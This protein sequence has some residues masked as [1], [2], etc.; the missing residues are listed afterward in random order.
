[1]V[2]A[3]AEDAAGKF[4]AG[5]SDGLLVRVTGD[6]LVEETSRTT[7]LSIRGLYATPNGDLWLGFA[8]G[9]VGRLRDGQLQRFTTEQG[10]PNDYVSQI[11]PDDRDSLWF[12]GNQGIFQVR[13]RDFDDVSRGIVTRLTPMIYGRGE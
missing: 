1:F 10:L 6:E 7:G 2:R 3:M 8:G 11:L 5:A 9:G 12:A 13:E 4:W